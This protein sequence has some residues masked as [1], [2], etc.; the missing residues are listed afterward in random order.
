M[1]AP[2][3]ALASEPRTAAPSEISLE[4][5]SFAELLVLY[6]VGRVGVSVRMA[7]L[8]GRTVSAAG[9][10]LADLGFRSGTV[11][12]T[13]EGPDGAPAYVLA[14]GSLSASATSPAVVLVSSFLHED[15]GWVR[16]F[17]QGDPSGRV[18]PAD[19]AC[20]VKT[21][22]YPGKGEPRLR[23]ALRITE[24]TEP[25]PASPRVAAAEE[26]AAAGFDEAKLR[27][28]REATIIA[29]T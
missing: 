8:R 28:G 15:L 23:E 9:R 25:Y 14:N 26:L 18:V 17:P 2:P 3:V 27:R 29:L 7:F 1:A 22:L 13:V 21:V 5:P 20:A 12:L 16:I 24:D 6:A 4:R 11:P 19:R 10:V